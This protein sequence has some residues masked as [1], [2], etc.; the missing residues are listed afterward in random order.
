MNR[1]DVENFTQFVGSF[2]FKPFGINLSAALKKRPLIKQLP[3]LVSPLLYD[4]PCS[5]NERNKTGQNNGP[6]KLCMID[7]YSVGVLNQVIKTYIAPVVDTYQRKIGCDEVGQLIS[8]L[9]K[10]HTDYRHLVEERIFQPNT[11]VPLMFGN[12]SSGLR[13]LT[14]RHI[15]HSALFDKPVETLA[16]TIHSLEGKILPLSPPPPV[17]PRRTLMPQISRKRKDLEEKIDALAQ[18]DHDIESIL[19]EPEVAVVRSSTPFPMREHDEE[20]LSRYDENW[21]LGEN[22]HFTGGGQQQVV[23]STLE[24]G[25]ELEISRDDSDRQTVTRLQ[26]MLQETDDR[27]EK[28]Q[29]EVGEVATTVPSSSRF[30]VED[31]KEESDVVDDTSDEEDD[32]DDDEEVKAWLPSSQKLEGQA[33]KSSLFCLSPFGKLT[34]K[35]NTED[36]PDPR[37]DEAVV[38]MLTP[39]VVEALRLK[40]GLPPGLRHHLELEVA[41][42]QLGAALFHHSTIKCDRGCEGN[43][44]ESDLTSDEDDDNASTT[45]WDDSLS[46]PTSRSNDQEDTSSSSSESDDEHVPSIPQRPRRLSNSSTSNDDSESIPE[47]TDDL[48]FDRL[49]IMEA[50]APS[51]EEVIPESSPNFFSFGGSDE[52]NSIRQYVQQIVQVTFDHSTDSETDDENEDKMPP[53]E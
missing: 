5:L 36:Q 18:D 30:M 49:V 11:L 45:S 7:K 35:V 43:D 4:S 22:P 23:L 50:A 48:A 2:G 3:P 42:L 10:I 8:D 33:G 16:K 1:T 12:I 34:P 17:R 26:R 24:G 41:R 13:Q 52:H 53:L 44:E 38:R 25:D 51:V 19:E 40:L 9:V 20:R 29:S 39:Q 28:L 46:E 15:L 21:Y 14:I 32:D 47:L 27:L 6:L 31:V 37:F